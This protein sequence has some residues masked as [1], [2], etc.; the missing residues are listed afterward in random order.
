MTAITNPIG[1]FASD[2]GATIAGLQARSGIQGPP[3]GIWLSSDEHTVLVSLSGKEGLYRF[4]F[5]QPIILV[6]GHANYGLL[7]W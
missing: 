6:D 7:F 4:F 5:I 1:M 3:D 2:L